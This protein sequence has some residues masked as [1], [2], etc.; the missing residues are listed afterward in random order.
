MTPELVK[1]S[2]QRTGVRPMD[3]EVILKRFNKHLQQDKALELRQHDCGDSWCELQEIFDAAV[4]D[5][6][7]V[8]NPAA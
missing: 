1:K 3:A 2:S 8:K 6:L 7:K 4:V 5:K